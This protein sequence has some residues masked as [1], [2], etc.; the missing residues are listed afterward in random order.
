MTTQS[1]PLSASDDT[2]PSTYFDPYRIGCL[3]CDGEG[4]HTCEN[5]RAR[6]EVD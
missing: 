3:G 6:P 2:V 1:A 5:Y 4:H